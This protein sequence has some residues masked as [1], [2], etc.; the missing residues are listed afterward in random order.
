M[1]ASRVAWRCESLKYAGTVM[2]ASVISSPRKSSAK[3]LISISTKAEI[4]SGENS[5]SR[6]LTFTSPLFAATML[7]GRTFLAWPT[8]SESNLRPIS[9]LMAKTVLNGLVMAWRLAIC[10][11]R[12]LAILGESDHGRSRAAS[13]P[14]GD[15]LRRRHVDDCHARIG[16]AE[17]D[18]DD[19]G[20]V[21]YAGALRP[22]HGYLHHR[23]A[24]QPVMEEIALLQHSHHGMRR[25]GRV[26][27]P[28]HRLMDVRIEMHAD[29]VDRLHAVPLQ[30]VEELFVD[31]QNA[32]VK[33]VAFLGVIERAIEV[34]EHGQDVAKHRA[35]GVFEEVR[36]L[37]LVAF[38]EVLVVGEGA[39]V[40]ILQL[41]VFRAKRP[42]SVVAV[43]VSVAGSSATASCAVSRISR[44]SSSTRFA[45][46]FDDVGVVAR[47]LL[48]VVLGPL[49]LVLLF[50]FDLAAQ[51]AAE[52]VDERRHPRVFHAHRA[53]DADHSERRCS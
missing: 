38:A 40:A 14:V 11:T 52:V 28:D 51:C 42:A 25:H 44:S 50:L 16:R 8:S 17:I 29:L 12:P 18:S 7:Y 27:F 23:R 24:K 41:L 6:I 36:L 32:L 5:R 47:I 48:V 45:G 39:E 13:L 21:V 15:H 31:Q 22:A 19:F 2:I 53:D 20:H 49:D 30:H 4:S 10:P 33:L 37:P 3:A 35:E 43:A 9:R 34:V 26:F 46:V 1:P